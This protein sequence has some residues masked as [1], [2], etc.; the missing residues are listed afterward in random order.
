MSERL[1]QFA[2]DAIVSYLQSHPDS[3]DTISGVH[4]WWILWPGTP[5]SIIVTATA[6]EQLEQ[7]HLVERRR[8]GNTE[9]WRRARPAKS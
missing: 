5:E 3:V 1:V 4:E 8:I 2:V 7:A 9:I 6:L